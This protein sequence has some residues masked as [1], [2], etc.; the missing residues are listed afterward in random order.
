MLTSKYLFL[1]GLALAAIPAL[2]TVP[3]FLGR[4]DALVRPVV[5][6]TE[7]Q[8]VLRDESFYEVRVLG[9]KNRICRLL[10]PILGFTVTNGVMS[11]AALTFPDDE[12]PGS[13]R[14]AGSQDFGVWRFD[15]TRNP[16][17]DHVMAYTW[18]DCGSPW[19]VL[20]QLGPWPVEETEN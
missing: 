20:T 14:P 6:V 10:P 13:S 2:A 5:S 7:T 4:V 9:T 16:Q 12:T 1:P 19:A 17:A 11:E 3:E 15:T 8:P 18:H